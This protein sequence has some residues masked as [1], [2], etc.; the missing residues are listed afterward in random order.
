[1]SIT[2]QPQDF[3]VLFLDMNSFFASVEQQVQPILR[4]VPI[5]VAPYT[6]PTGCII[7]ASREA[8]QWG[9]KVARIDEARKLCPQIKII[10]ARPALYMI[11][12]KEI[13][14]VIESFT[15][16]FEVLSVDE[17]AI[18][19]TQQDQSYEKSLELGRKIKNAIRERVGDSL[20]CSVGIGPS[21]FLAKM[22]GERKKPDGLEIV[23]LKDL[24]A[25]YAGLKLTDLTGINWRL[26]KRLKDLG[27]NSPADLYN[28]SLMKLMTMMQHFGRMWY[29][30]LRG[31][32]VDSSIIRHKTI[33]HSHVL[34]PE[35]RTRQGAMAVLRKLI[36]K[37]G[38]RLRK[39][40]F[41]AGGISL[42]IGFFDHQRFALSK[43]FLPF[44]DN[45]TFLKNVDNLLQTCRWT[46][47]PIF[48]AIS[49]FNLTRK[50][51]EQL[52]I[53]AEIEKSRELSKALDELNDEF[54]AETVF[55][56]SMFHGKDSAPDRI[57]FGR[58][59]YEIL[60][61]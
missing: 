42:S 55:P 4:G 58:P 54:G 49:T 3:K 23:T 24:K 31:Y 9:I 5:G 28:S 17:F 2:E 38:Y 36:F 40:G 1:M 13:K 52:S 18:R 32:E 51:R 33:G 8:K 25:F 22:A 34:E 35:F 45:D 16:Y 27:I 29:F 7:S 20:T 15:P 10:E 53:F 50:D 47:K 46:N 12:H 14:K 11:Y 60:H 41:S 59:R 30:R 37:T 19:L 43:K 61:Q 21:V 57:P 48:L 6:G 26:E 39:E 44:S 56:A